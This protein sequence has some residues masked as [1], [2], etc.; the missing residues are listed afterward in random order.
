M[1]FGSGFLLCLFGVVTQGQKERLI[2][3]PTFFEKAQDYR[4]LPEFERKTYTTG[5]MDGFYASALFGADGKAAEKLNACTMS[6]DSKQ[7][8]AIVSK[9][10]EDHPGRVEL[11]VEHAGIQRYE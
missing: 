6:M 3:I 7:I 10:V 11:P 2:N 9:Y 5:L 1:A 8:T 4:D